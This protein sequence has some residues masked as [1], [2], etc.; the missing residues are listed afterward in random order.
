MSNEMRTFIQE[1]NLNRQKIYLTE[2]AQIDTDYNRETADWQAYHG[3]ELLELIQNADDEANDVLPKKIRVS[4]Q[5]GLLTISNYGE[6]FSRDGIISLMY[7]NRS[8]KRERLKESIG[9]KGTGFRSIL[10]WADVITIHSGDLHIRFSN[11]FSQRMLKET[12]QGKQ[13]LPKGTKAA[14]LAF[15]EWIIDDNMVSEYTTTIELKVKDNEEIITDINEQI[16]SIDENVLLFLNR[17]EELELCIPGETIIFRK[18]LVG[19]I[20]NLSKTINGK[21][22]IE[23][24]WTT[25]SKEGR[26]IDEADEHKEKSSRLL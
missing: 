24:S 20:V 6:P 13:D 23:H 8:P 26:L 5:N 22:V 10:S 4:F 14:V 18:A 16:K 19:N 3:R 7:S 9:N 1:K 11:E 15:P 12:F 17:T 21:T 2:A 25:I